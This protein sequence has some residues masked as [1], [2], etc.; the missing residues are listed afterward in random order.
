MADGALILPPDDI[1]KKGTKQ[2]YGTPPEL[3]AA[4]E[5]RFGR[6]DWDLAAHAGNA[7]APYYLDRI[8]D[9]LSRDWSELTGLAWLNPPFEDIGPWA[10]KCANHAS[11]KL[12]IVALWIASID[13]DW[14][15][16]HVLR[17]AFSFGISRV[18]FVGETHGYPKPLM[19]SIF[20]GVASGFGPLWKWRRE[21]PKAPRKPRHAAAVGGE[22]RR[23][24]VKRRK[25]DA[26]GT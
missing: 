19:I 1:G 16:D 24:K 3:I 25:S 11:P 8:D 17:N 5:Q 13:A 22:V 7:C 26:N 6:I 2:D 15:T 14:F 9:S 18:T 23:V 12:V 4:V 21:L 10:E 20:N